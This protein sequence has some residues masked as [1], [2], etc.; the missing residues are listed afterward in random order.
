MV[1]LGIFAV[2]LLLVVHLSKYMGRSAL[3]ANV[4]VLA[5]GLVT[6][7]IGEHAPGM[8]QLDPLVDPLARLA[9]FTIL[10]AD[11]MQVDLGVL[12]AT[13]QDPARALAIG[14]PLTLAG[15][16]LLARWVT[17]LGWIPS[18]V[19]GAILTPTDPAFATLIVER[20]DV[21][22][23]LRTTLNLESGLNDGIMPPLVLTL[24]AL[25]SGSH[26]L[27]LG[28]WIGQAF[29]GIGLG[30]VL[31]WIALQAARRWPHSVEEKYGPVEALAIGILVLAS[32]RLTGANELLA[33][34]SAGI[35][36]NVLGREV[37]EEFKKI[38]RAL[39]EILKLA[40]VFV[41]AAMIFPGWITSLGARDWIYAILALVL[42]RPIALLG[43]AFVGS[44]LGLRERVVVAW[45]GPKGF[46]SLY[47]GL[48][49][50]E[51]DLADARRV[52]QITAA[53]VA[54]S[55]VAHSSTD[56]HMARFV[57]RQP[58]PA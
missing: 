32:S 55:I 9:V 11:G 22:E 45:F 15:N 57:K 39:T 12:R 43:V 31:A 24:L 6:G 26:E 27:R 4:L 53:T 2:T 8:P 56:L 13:W 21:P 28:L 7:L 49:A 16:T 29:L 30:A 20:E 34:F 44:K 3:S 23:R 58:A 36:I 5:A 33:A 46:A 41:F 25:G 1:A 42:V 35:T 48:L 14:L 10:F 47:F 19:L 17:G 38:E 18:A 50:L 54:L 52:F 51:S 37:K 40:A